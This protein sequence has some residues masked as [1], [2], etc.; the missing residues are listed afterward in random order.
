MPLGHTLWQL[1]WPKLAPGTPPIDSDQDG[2]PDAW[3]KTHGLNPADAGDSR[4]D[5]DNDGY[6]NIEEYL[7]RTDPTKYVEHP[8]G[9]TRGLTQREANL[10]GRVER[11]GIVLE[12]PHSHWQGRFGPFARR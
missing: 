11:V 8:Y 1:G 5:L 9:D 4:I 10:R 3:E 2:T 7:N 12:H 6:T